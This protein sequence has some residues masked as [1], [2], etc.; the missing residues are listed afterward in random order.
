MSEQPSELDTTDVRQFD[1]VLVD[2]SV[3]ARRAARAEADARLTAE[4]NDGGRIKRFVSGIWK[5]NIAKDY[6]RQKYERQALDQIEATQDILIH[7]TASVVQRDGAMYATICRFQSEYDEMVHDDAGER[8]AELSDTRITDGLKSIVREYADGRLDDAGLT[9]ERAR[10]LQAYRDEHGNELFGDGLVQVDNLLQVAR[11]VKGAVSH[12][13]SLDEIIEGMRIITAESRAGVR[14]DVDYSRTDQVIEKLGKSK[15]GLI[16]GSEATIAAASIA[17]S[18]V[19]FGSTRAVGAAAMTI[20]PGI[21]AGLLAGLRERKHVKDD[22]AQHAREVA[23]GKT[24]DDGD[25]RRVEMDVTR[26]ETVRATDLTQEVRDRLEDGALETDDALTRALDSLAAIRA[27]EY[28]SD[29]RGIDLIAYSDVSL[30]EQERFDLALARA[31]LKVAL[32]HRLD[33]DARQRLSLDEYADIDEL[34]EQTSSVFIETYQQDIDAKDEVFKKLKVRRVAKAAAI[35]AAAGLTFGLAAQELGASMSSTREGL[36]E[37][38][39]GHESQLHDGVM[40]ETVLQGMLGSEQGGNGSGS[41]ERV[42]AAVASETVTKFGEQTKITHTDNLRFEA[43]D[44]RLLISSSNGESIADVKLRSDGSIGDTAA[45]RLRDAGMNVEDLSRT[46]MVETTQTKTVELSEFMQNHRDE[47]TRISRDLWYDNDTPA[48]VFEANEL[49]LH[50]GGNGGA[51][52]D[53]NIVMSVATMQADGSFHGAE[54]TNW[55]QDAR[56]EKLKLAISPSGDTQARPFMVDINQ[57]GTVRI[58]PGNPAAQFFSNENGQM[59]FNGRYAEVVELT[60]RDTEGVELVRPLATLVGEDTIQTLRDTVTTQVAELRPRY[61]ITMP[62]DA[63]VQTPAGPKTFVEMAPVIPVVGRRSME[64][65]RTESG[66]YYGE[67]GSPRERS[68]LLRHLDRFGSPRLRDN[69]DAKLELGEELEWYAAQTRSA[70]GDAYVDSIERT[71]AASPE[72]SGIPGS[73]ESIVTIPV[74]ASGEEESAG[75]YDQLRMFASQ[76]A[77]AVAKNLMLLHVNWPIAAESDP[78]AATRIQQTKDEIERARRDFPELKVATVESRW[79]QQDLAGGVIG[80]V[81]DTMRD[82]ALLSLRRAVED[83]RMASDHDVQVIRNDADAKG[84][85]RNYLRNFQN[86][87]RT[88]EEA[89]IFTGTT[90]FDE[91]RAADLPGMVLG[92]HFAQTINILESARYHKAHTGGANFGVR[93]A[94]LAAVAPALQQQDFKGVGSDDVMVGVYIDAARNRSSYY[95]GDTGRAKRGIQSTYGSAY[96]MR[97]ESGGRKIARRVVG[98]QIDTDSQRSEEAYLDG[99]YFHNTWDLDFDDGGHRERGSGMNN[100]SREDRRNELAADLDQQVDIL[101]KD[102]QY[103]VKIVGGLANPAVKT[104]LEMLFAGANKPGYSVSGGVVRLTPEGRTFLVNRMRRDARG[105]FDPLGSRLSRQLY[106]RTGSRAK[107]QRPNA[108][109]FSAS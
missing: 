77:D 21:G 2:Q 58:E 19:R 52:S 88:D 105:R 26:Y 101:E 3:D 53:G 28:L 68:G 43:R 60:G 75:I 14:T 1:V 10:L 33:D 44:G 62:P 95:G 38:A 100:Q 64:A 78:D 79:T 72:L 25:Q 24:F 11:A 39:W 29:T 63:L 109:L 8:K 48:P 69:P 13:N 59:V 91:R 5:G 106:G 74:K 15:L 89:D 54:S 84:I 92:Q 70:R 107:L 30:V 46:V 20:A 82:A 90:R 17:A 81:A 23:Q 80:R 87:L 22:R 6:Y 103:T 18:V 50:W 104:S 41:N 66:G 102:I 56:T 49:G 47:T 31:E 51:D 4:L 34:L 96:G 40:H 98:A 61:E 97:S 94:A 93:A 67:Y 27:R 86:S 83:G 76:D 12:G 16:M 108:P 37:Q 36:L 65:A 99:G 32:R 7:E 55:S 9:E 85:H 57:D 45:G 35:G 71:I 42:G 73:T